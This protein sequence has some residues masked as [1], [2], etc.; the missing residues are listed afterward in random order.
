MADDNKNLSGDT[1][2]TSILPQSEPQVV[3]QTEVLPTH[4]SQVE[5]TQMPPVTQQETSNAFAGTPLESVAGA[6]A[7]DQAGD[8]AVAGCRWKVG[9]LKVPEGVAY[10]GA[11]GSAAASE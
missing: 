5:T 2:R 4:A 3:E 11:R 7:D 6:S 8:E 10:D 9:A 1:E